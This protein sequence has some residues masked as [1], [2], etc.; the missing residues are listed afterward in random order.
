VISPRQNSH[1]QKVTTLIVFQ[2]SKKEG[3]IA[4][5]KM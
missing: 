4:N 3:K 1:Q 5:K 2:D